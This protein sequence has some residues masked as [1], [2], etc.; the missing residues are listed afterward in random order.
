VKLV[1]PAGQRAGRMAPLA[2]LFARRLLRAHVP[3]S[4][5]AALSELAPPGLSVVMAAHDEE[6]IIE[7][8]LKQLVGLADEIVVVDAGS[9]DRT[10]EI[11]ARLA[12]RVVPTSNKPMLE[13]NKNIAMD[14][15]RH[16]WVLVLDPDERISPRLRAQI[17]EVVERDSPEIAG[18]WMPRRNYI[19]GRWVR[20]M[21]MYPGSQL[22]LVRRGMGRFDEQRHHLPMAVRGE[23][24]YLSGD[25]VHLSDSTVEEILEKRRRYADYAARQMFESGVRF[26]VARMLWEV[27]GTFARQYV[28]LGGWLEG[29]VG[30]RYAGLSAYGA[31]RRHWRLR[32]LEQGAAGARQ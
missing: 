27:C 31:W 13:I 5:E 17:R 11:A 32:R 30:L 23:V 26:S 28:L 2:Q 4:H 12:H 25:L 19:L 16:A 1:G 14:A 24:G 21:G 3:A 8:A 18:Y 10:A 15:A 29:S 20:A 6:H 9:R 7:G 22:R